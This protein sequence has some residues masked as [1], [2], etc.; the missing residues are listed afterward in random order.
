[1]RDKPSSAT[2][3][4][5]L[6]RPHGQSKFT[7]AGRALGGEVPLLPTPAFGAPGPI[8]TAGLQLRRL[9]LYPTELRGRNPSFGLGVAARWSRAWVPCLVP[10]QP[11]QHRHSDRKSAFRCATGGEPAKSGS[12]ATKYWRARADSNGRLLAPQA[13]ALSPELR[14]RTSP[15]GLADPGGGRL[16][17]VFCFRSHNFC[18]VRP[19]RFERP[20]SCSGGKRSI[21]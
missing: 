20:T 19:G 2:S 3:P 1:V 21:H 4:L 18:L 14:A 16:C 17:P 6:Q 10:P 12:S 7:C 8:R 5:E 9:L 15:T 11:A 13:S